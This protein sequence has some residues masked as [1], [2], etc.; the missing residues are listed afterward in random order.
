MPLFNLEKNLEDPLEPKDSFSR[1]YLT[2]ISAYMWL[3]PVDA[4]LI[5]QCVE[6]YYVYAKKLQTSSYLFL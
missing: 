4:H 1:N 6:N 3:L 5:C 2:S